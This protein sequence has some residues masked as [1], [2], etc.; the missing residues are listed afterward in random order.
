MGS[1]ANVTFK[2]VK[3]VAPKYQY[4]LFEKK[5]QCLLQI[6]IDVCTTDYGPVSPHSR[7]GRP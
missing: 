6:I 3:K 7:P 2:Y 1:E 4:L 5:K